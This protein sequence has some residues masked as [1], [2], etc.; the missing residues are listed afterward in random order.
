MTKFTACKLHYNYRNIYQRYIYISPHSTHTHTHTQKPNTRSIL[1]MQD[2]LYFIMIDYTCPFYY[3]STET[4]FNNS[5]S[6]YFFY[7]IHHTHATHKKCYIETQ[8]TFDIG[9]EIKL[10]AAGAEI[11]VV[12]GLVNDAVILEDTHKWVCFCM[13]MYQET[14]VRVLMEKMMRLQGRTYIYK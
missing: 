11:D 13:C 6:I 5:L 8:I 2:K 9:S 3:G 12:D 1:C 14:R 4:S 7:L 10:I